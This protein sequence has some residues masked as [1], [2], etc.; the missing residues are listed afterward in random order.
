MN[1]AL[2]G[3]VALVGSVV[4]TIIKQMYCHHISD[5]ISRQSSS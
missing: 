5:R 1:Q 2:R 3:K 4:S